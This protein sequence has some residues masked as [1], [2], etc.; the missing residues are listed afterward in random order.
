MER[1][2]WVPRTYLDNGLG[3]SAAQSG[4]KMNATGG[5]SR[6]R[7]QRLGEGETRDILV[8]STVLVL[9]ME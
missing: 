8:I 9:I 4:Q 3:T 7:F 6:A 1:T 5:K 2:I